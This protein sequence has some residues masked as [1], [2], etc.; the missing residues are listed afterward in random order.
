M[1]DA[2]RIL[3][4]LERINEAPLKTEAVRQAL[5]EDRLL[6]L[7]NAQVL[8]YLPAEGPLERLS[9]DLIGFG[10]P[11]MQQYFKE[12]LQKATVAAKEVAEKAKKGS[13]SWTYMIFG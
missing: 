13:N 3:N 5:G 6:Q 12:R 4:V 2:E 10:S 8:G 9:P 7:L 11:A 1:Q